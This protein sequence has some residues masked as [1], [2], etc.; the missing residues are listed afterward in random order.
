[1]SR[2][3]VVLVSGLGVPSG[4]GSNP[5]IRL[6]VSLDGG[7]TWGSERRTSAG[8]MGQYCI[9]PYWVGLS[10]SETSW[11]PEVSVSDPVPYRLSQAFIEGQGL[12]A[13]PAPQGGP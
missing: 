12:T 1:V 9:R 5:D 2:F 6:R 13:A 10:S 11:T 3:E 4:P 7:M 8:R